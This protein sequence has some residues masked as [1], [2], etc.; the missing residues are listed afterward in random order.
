MN[1][2]VYTRFV[3]RMVNL[4]DLID[5]HAVAELIGLSQPNNVSLYQRRYPDMPRPVLNLGKG[6]P[7]LWLQS[8]IVK[9]A[10]QTGRIS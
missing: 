9:W 10:K 6:R 2:R 1:R 4:Y 5:A 3:K 7:C 8:E